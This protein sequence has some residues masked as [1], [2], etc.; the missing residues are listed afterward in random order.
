MVY[1][2]N[3][4]FVILI[5]FILNNSYGQG[6]L[7]YREIGDTIPDIYLKSILGTEETLI[8]LSQFKGLYVVLDFWGIHC[9]PCIASMPKID[10]LQRKYQKNVKFIL[11]N[12]GLDSKNMVRAFLDKK[13]EDNEWV[14]KLLIVYG[15]SLSRY[16]AFKSI[17]HY[18]WLNEQGKIFAISGS[19]AITEANIDKVIKCGTV[20][21]Y[22]EKRDVMP[23]MLLPLPINYNINLLDNVVLF[24]KGEIKEISSR[25]GI[26][27]DNN[28]LTRGLY[29]INS[30]LIRTYQF[31]LRQIGGLSWAYDQKRLII[32]SK[33]SI[34]LY[35]T[36]KSD[37]YTFDF[38]DL[39]IKKDSLFQHVLNYLNNSSPYSLKI[40]KKKMKCYILTKKTITSISQKFIKEIDDKS[41]ANLI[42]VKNYPL[43]WFISNKLNNLSALILPII[44]ETD[45]KGYL[46]ITIP[47]DIKFNSLKKIL[48]TNGL[49]LKEG[50]REIEMAIIIKNKR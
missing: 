45:D 30:S 14:K 6:T 18:V 35:S 23:D 25:N 34:L 8:N 36:K 4:I 17:P 27:E 2:T 3:I 33:D 48:L 22:K 37:L 13:S 16:F 42:A 32:S 39:K 21:A 29:V 20:F 1:K 11:V 41:T 15:D 7:R 19:E 10:S 40:H 24:N 26:R 31:I 44:N 28:G 50:K 12:D 46:D 5:S 49:V 9:G 38:W 47:R 43:N